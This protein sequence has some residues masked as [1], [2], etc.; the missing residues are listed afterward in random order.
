MMMSFARDSCSNQ[1][2]AE[3]VIP[4]S[5]GVVFVQV[6][7]FALYIMFRSGGLTNP[8]WIQSFLFNWM[9]IA[10]TRSE[11]THCSLNNRHHAKKLQ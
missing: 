9:I 8:T 1:E 7:G 5:D 10:C 11:E 3:S 4:Y 2:V 6:V